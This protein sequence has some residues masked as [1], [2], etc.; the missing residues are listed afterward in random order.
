MSDISAPRERR[1]RLI[2]LEGIDGSGKSTQYAR[3]CARLEAE[4]R[5]FRKVKFP[6]YEEESSALIRQYL[7]GDFGSDPGDVNP[8]AASVMYAVDRFASYMTDWRE[9][10]KSGGLVLL[11][12]YTT[13]NAC[14]QG[15]KLPAERRGEF[16]DWLYGFE[17]RLLE[18][19][20]PD[21]VLYLDTDISVSR[22]RMAERQSDTGESADIHEKNAAY[23]A[24]CLEAGHYA[25]SHYGWTVIKC[26]RD[27][28]MR[29][30]DDIHEEIYAKVT[31]VI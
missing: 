31:E 3:L 5:D 11:D 24:E 14:H 1:G 27:G 19:P 26:V 25:A 20:E 15:S 23:L 4:G 8:Y 6:R 22:R 2:V 21:L 10:Y 9:Y 30:I 28:Q 29:A 12:R 13:S 16:C 17:F 7:R 18:L